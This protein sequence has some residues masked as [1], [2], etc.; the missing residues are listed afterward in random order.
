MT[1][2]LSFK[3][4][5]YDLVAQIP[6]G[7]VMSYGQIA[8]LC[9]KPGAARLVGQIAHFGSEDLPWH[10][11]VNKNGQMASGYWGGKLVHANHLTEEGVEIKDLKITNLEKYLW[12]PPILH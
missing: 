2:T 6:E 9:D 1:K 8:L 12:Q 7:R 5:V 4:Q 3:Q 11:V 10:R